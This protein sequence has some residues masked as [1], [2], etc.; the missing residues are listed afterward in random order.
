[1]VKLALLCVGFVPA[2][3]K[4]CGFLGHT[5]RLGCSKCLKE[6]QGVPGSMCYGGFDR[7]SWEPCILADHTVGPSSFMPI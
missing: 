1:M 4:L 7:D 5:A 2:T 3:W 6:F